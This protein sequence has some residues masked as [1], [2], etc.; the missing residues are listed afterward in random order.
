VTLL[1]SAF[2]LPLTMSVRCSEPNLSCFPISSTALFSTPGAVLFFGVVREELLILKLRPEILSSP[3]N[4]LTIL[5]S[6][7]FA[8]PDNLRSFLPRHPD[9]VIRWCSSCQPGSV[10]L[11]TPF[12]SLNSSTCALFKYTSP[13][14]NVH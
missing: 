7:C 14:T 3:R 8:S 4:R 5:S 10:S 2:R 12:H 1:I 9:Y 11:R 13:C 6:R